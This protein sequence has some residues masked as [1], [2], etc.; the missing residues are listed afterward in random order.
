FPPALDNEPARRLRRYLAVEYAGKA[1]PGE[2]AALLGG[3]GAVELAEPDGLV[4]A[5]FAPDDSLFAQQWAHRN[6]GQAVAFDSSLVGAPDCDTDTDLA[7]DY[8]TGDPGLVLAI[9]DSGVD[10]AHEEFAGRIVA[11]YDFVHDDDDP[12]DDHGHGTACAGIAAAAAGS[13]QGIAGVGWNLRIMPVK[14][15]DQSGDGA[16]GD[17]ASGVVWAVDQGALVLSLSLGSYLYSSLIEDAVAYAHQAGCA[18]F[19]AAGNGDHAFLS[20]PAAYSEFTIPVGALSPCNERKSPTSCDG[21]DW[22][23]SNYGDLAFLA[24][25]VRMHTTDITGAEGYTDGRYTGGFNG[26]S[27]ATPHA[28]AIGCLVLS[29]NPALT[30]TQLEYCLTRSSED[31]GTLGYDDETGFGRLNAHLAVLGA[32][33]VP[34]Y[35]RA[36]YAGTEQGTL[37]RPYNTLVEGIAAAPAGGTVVVFPGSYSQPT[38]IA[39]SL[40][41][42]AKDG[43]ATVG[44]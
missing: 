36:S 44:P 29:R 11:G 21:E 39:K 33:A 30:P 2:V 10:L 25:G 22:W 19:C 42:V 31:M 38:T 16:F 27:A 12:T 17:V 5:Q 1:R 7:W 43:I 40:T 41:I 32:F 28:A 8:A 15:L 3:S 4:H 37:H 18:V 9:I 26:T 6:T 24:P 14:V 20:Y 13:G 34:T 23:G 35:V